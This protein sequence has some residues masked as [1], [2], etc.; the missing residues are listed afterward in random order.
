MT[1]Q[2]KVTPRRWLPTSRVAN[3]QASWPERASLLIEVS[4]GP[5]L[6]GRGEAAP[7]PR[8]SPDTL[9]SAA[10][11]LS[12]VSLTD[13]PEVDELGRFGAWLGGVVPATEPAA[14]FA[15]ETALLDLAARREQLPLHVWLR[16]RLSGPALAPLC[17]LELAAL[18]DATQGAGL[19]GSAGRCLAE[20][21]RTLKFKLGAA[22]QFAEELS[23]LSAVRANLGY[24]F[25]MRLDANQGF[26]IALAKQRLV[27]LAP[28][29]IEL[30][31]EPSTALLSAPALPIALDESLRQHFPALPATLREHGVAV[32]VLKPTVLGGLVACAEL[33]EQ[34]RG[35]KLSTV[36]SHT[37]EGPVA[38]SAACELALA[39]GQ[40]E[41]A[42]GL[43]PHAALGES[44]ASCAAL[45]GVVLKPHTRLGLGLLD[46]GPT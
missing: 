6:L 19:V 5:G 12:A 3:A 20:G 37:F 44:A 40:S 27:E 42:H 28:L 43:A 18:L 13:V 16:R 2:L 33:C 34:A 10:A 22:G 38:F 39:L 4:A 24:G 17:E 46:A 25:R 14:R 45:Q 29:D 8:Y 26:P 21:Y 23:A 30:I 1:L 31:E 41:L 35:A 7:L 36:V 11:A 15:L 9:A 32:L